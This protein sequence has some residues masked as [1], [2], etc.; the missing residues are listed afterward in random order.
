MAP[1]R[2]GG[3]GPCQSLEK[4]LGHD[5]FARSK[6][7]AALAAIENTKYTQSQATGHVTGPQRRRQWLHQES[8]T[9]VDGHDLKWSMASR[10]HVMALQADRVGGYRAI[11]TLPHG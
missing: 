2:M 9:T 7:Q 11:T 1:G 6:K 5:E 3:G 4:R 10:E 8:H